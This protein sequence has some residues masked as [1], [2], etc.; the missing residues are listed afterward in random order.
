MSQKIKERSVQHAVGS[1]ST[2]GFAESATRR[3]NPP[4]S[5]AT[6]ARTRREFPSELQFGHWSMK[7]PLL[8]DELLGQFEI[9][10]NRWIAERD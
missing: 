2:L 9:I 8:Y 5:P 3:N 7:A 6:P 4:R 10:E 1:S